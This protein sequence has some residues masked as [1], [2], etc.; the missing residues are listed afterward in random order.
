MNI[1]QPN[2]DYLQALASWANNLESQAQRNLQEKSLQVEWA[3]EMGDR[4]RVAQLLGYNPQFENAFYQESPTLDPQ[5]AAL[6][7]MKDLAV[8]QKLSGVT[9]TDAERRGTGKQVLPY[10][11]SYA[12]NQGI[13]NLGLTPDE[14]SGTKIPYKESYSLDQKITDADMS[15]LETLIGLKNAG[16]DGPNLV[17][18]VAN[19]GQ[20][21]TMDWA[22][23]G[24]A[25]NELDQTYRDVISGAKG[26]VADYQKRKEYYD[27]HPELQKKY[28]DA[29]T[30]GGM[31]QQ[32]VNAFT[33]SL[34]GKS[35]SEARRLYAL[36]IKSLTDT[37]VAYKRKDAEN[38]LGRFSDW[39]RPT[40]MGG[41]PGGK[42]WTFT[43]K[44]KKVNKFLRI[45]DSEPDPK[46][47]AEKYYG[48]RFHTAGPAASMG[49]ADIIDE[50]KGGAAGQ[51]SAKEWQDKFDK[52]YWGKD[53]IIEQARNAGVH[54]DRKSNKFYVPMDGEYSGGSRESASD[55]EVRSRIDKYK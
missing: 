4:K 33:A 18:N 53:E 39:Y 46:A 47:Y 12:L 5:Q 26:N 43:T 36:A 31:Q 17:S 50:V 10:K 27:K 41:G 30:A 11:E 42:V 40:G 51:Y 28:L 25:R 38:I 2:N 16:I 37:G 52:A 19:Y 24:K 9:L 35:E 48:I 32:I 20:G 49:G 21:A 8:G 13:N 1:V 45:P 54:F 3:R 55:A 44:D 29:E 15:G 22:T 6:A 14:I 34:P 23:G 7:K